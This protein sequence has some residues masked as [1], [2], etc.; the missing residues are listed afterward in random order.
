MGMDAGD[1]QD[2]DLDTDL[3]DAIEESLEDEIMGH[4]PRALLTVNNPNAPTVRVRRRQL[5]TAFYQNRQYIR[6]LQAEQQQLA[7]QLAQ[8]G[9]PLGDYFTV[10]GQ[11]RRWTPQEREK[12]A[13]RIRRTDKGTALMSEQSRFLFIWGPSLVVGGGALA[14]ILFVLAIIIMITA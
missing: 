7:E 6:Q 9:G 10:R 2:D 5:T 1:T 14:I 12:V 11:L 4:V 8:L 3:A 13:R